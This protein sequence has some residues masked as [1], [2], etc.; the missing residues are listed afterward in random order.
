VNPYAF[1]V[2]CPR[3]GTTLLGRIGNAHPQLAIV[4]E[5]RWIPRCFEYREGLT[6]DGLVTPSLVGRLRDRRVLGPLAIDADEMERL[7]RDAGF[8]PARRRQDYSVIAD[9]V[10][11]A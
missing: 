5:T 1:F 11:A 4:H 6:Q 9:E 7:I 2:G 8:T 10:V 3:S